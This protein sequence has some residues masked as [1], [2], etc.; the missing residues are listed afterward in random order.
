MKRIW[1]VLLAALCG[2]VL[3]ALVLAFDTVPLPLLPEEMRA[4][5]MYVKLCRYDGQSM[6]VAELNV[7]TA[8]EFLRDIS[9]KQVRTADNWTRNKRTGTIYGVN[10]STPSGWIDAAWCN[11]YWFCED[12]SLYRLDYDFERFAQQHGL[13]EDAEERSDALTM[14]CIR[15]LAE[16]Q[17]GWDAALL[18]KAE[19]L[20]PPSVI[21]MELEEWTDEMVRVT[22]SNASPFPWTVGL[23]YEIHVLLDGEWYKAAKMPG[24]WA[25]A[26][27]GFSV[28]PNETIEHRSSLAMYGTLPPGTYRYV[29]EGVAVEH[30]IE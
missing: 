26:L 30:T 12:G 15:Y 18:P 19:E 27:V 7:P 4:E 16:D 5:P 6:K 17:N 11:G 21:T 22:I 14:P 23:A 25:I 3:T 2:A 9:A 28:P 29:V 24:S 1:A 10:I 8:E 13:W 20:D